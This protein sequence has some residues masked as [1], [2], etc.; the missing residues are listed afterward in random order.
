MEEALS[1]PGSILA[2]GRAFEGRA[3]L[4]R[5][6][7]P[8]GRRC[9]RSWPRADGRARRSIATSPM[10]PRA[11]PG[12]SGTRRGGVLTHGVDCG[13]SAD[14]R[15]GLRTRR[16]V[17][18]TCVDKNH[19]L[20]PVQFQFLENP[21]HARLLPRAEEDD[22]LDAFLRRWPPDRSAA[23]SPDSVPGRC[24]WPASSRS[25]SCPWRREKSCS[26]PGPYHRWP[27][28]PTSDGEPNQT[29]LQRICRSLSRWMATPS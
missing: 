7:R 3:L 20:V 22:R 24:S 15:L 27:H 18:L 9:G 13:A 10:V 17:V 28:V 19:V 16:L 5:T 23:A 25:G 8:A 1:W 29:N 11:S 6:R 14:H 26:R 12:C 2:N 4:G 21:F